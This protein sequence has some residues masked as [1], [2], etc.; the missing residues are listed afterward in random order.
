MPEVLEKPSVDKSHKP[1]RLCHIWNGYDGSYCGM[2]KTER[3]VKPDTVHS[4]EYC[5][6]A[7]QICVVCAAEYERT[8]G[9]PW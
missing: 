2:K 6:Q 4:R 7:H 5:K 3:G 8:M 9:R 1:P